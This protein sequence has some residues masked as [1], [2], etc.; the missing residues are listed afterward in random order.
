MAETTNKE[1]VTIPE[2]ME[3]FSQR[4]QMYTGGTQ[5]IFERLGPTV[6]AALYDFFNVSYERVEW[7]DIQV[8]GGI[9]VIIATIMYKSNEPSAPIIEHLAPR[10]PEDVESVERIVKIGIPLVLIPRPKEEIMEFLRAH[11]RQPEA[12]KEEPI[13]TKT[14]DN[15]VPVTTASSA[16][17]GGFNTADLSK[18]QIRQLL[19]HQHDS[20]EIKH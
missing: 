5:Q 12:K 14:E 17:I 20:K 3:L 16:K 11:V 19:W 9:V 7:M 13:G 8:M 1:P 18:E 6:L 10:T 4:E 15:S 2:L